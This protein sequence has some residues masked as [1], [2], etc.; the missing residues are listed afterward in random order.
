M[1]ED[2]CKPSE[3]GTHEWRVYM[4]GGYKCVYCGTEW[5]PAEPCVDPDEIE[6][7]RFVEPEPLWPKVLGVVIAIMLIGLV[8][9]PVGVIK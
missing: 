8:F 6:A 5:L 9:G 3:K 1:N 7:H 2:V 4:S